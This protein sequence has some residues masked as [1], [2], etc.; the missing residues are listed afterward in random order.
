MHTWL[1]LTEQWIYRQVKNIQGIEQLVVCDK[2]S[3]D[4]PEIV[5]TYTNSSSLYSINN[6]IR[7]KLGMPDYFRNKVLK[8]YKDPILFSHYGTRGFLDLGLKKQK[9]ITRFYGYDL[10]RT[11]KSDPV[12]Q[13][14]YEKLFRECD[15]FIVEGEHMKKL[16]TKL[17]CEENK[18]KVSFLGADAGDIHFIKREERKSLNVLIACATAERKGIIYSLQAIARAINEYRIPIHIHWVGGRNSSY[19]PYIRYEKLLNEYIES[20]GLKKHINSYGFLTPLE[21]R[22]VA[23]LCQIA[24][25]PS[26]WAEDGDCEGGYPVVLVDMMATG[27]PVISTDHCDIPQLVNNEN[28]YICPEKDVDALVAALIDAYE[29]KSYIEK[30]VLARKIVEEKFDWKILGEEL[31]GI[32]LD[33]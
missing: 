32:I 21:L 20:S 6:R 8:K 29:T 19:E 31:S 30:S 18:I 13:G 4:I 24:I 23:E 3:N 5:K 1:P 16:L 12:W 9:H 7:N 25:H 10:T 33:N 14:R 17:G 11:L 27:L 28:G 22:S 26:V 2:K 15:Q